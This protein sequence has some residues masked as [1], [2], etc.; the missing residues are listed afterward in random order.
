ML[1]SNIFEEIWTSRERIFKLIKHLVSLILYDSC[2]ACKRGR[3]RILGTLLVDHRCRVDV[4]I[5]V[6]A[7]HKIFI[8]FKLSIWSCQIAHVRFNAWVGRI[9]HVFSPVV[10]VWGLEITLFRAERSCNVLAHR[11]IEWTYRDTSWLVISEALITDC[12]VLW[13]GHLSIT[14]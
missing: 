6:F 11:L 1:L 13:S 7:A 8:P 4:Q 5:V 10:I 3:L 9:R 2:V 14:L 12:I